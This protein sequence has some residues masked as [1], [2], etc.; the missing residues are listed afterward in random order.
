MSRLARILGGGDMDLAGL[1]VKTLL[2][3]AIDAEIRAGDIYRKVA[4]RVKNYVLKE[5]L[6]FLAGEEDKHRGFLQGLFSK[7]YPDEQ[8][9]EVPE[10]KVPL[11]A[12]KVD[13]EL[14]PIS[15]ILEQAMYAEAAAKDFYA[16]LADRVEDAETSRMLRF[17]SS[18]EEGHYKLLENELE[19]ARRFEDYENMWDM[20]HVGP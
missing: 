10:G 16:S 15:R 12:I 7:T 3:A 1:D 17:L 4:N 2:S 5:R 18:M 13:T 6:T 11:P 14:D 8:P 20:M 9:L 19:N